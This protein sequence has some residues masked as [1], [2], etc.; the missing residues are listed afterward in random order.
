MQNSATKIEKTEN[1]RKPAR[2][3]RMSKAEKKQGKAFRNARTA[4]K[5]RS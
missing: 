5:I 4:R 1:R 3:Q 2:N